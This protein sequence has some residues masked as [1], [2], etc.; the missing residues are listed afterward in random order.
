MDNNSLVKMGRII[1]LSD[2]M[3]EVIVNEG[4]VIDMDMVKE[5]H[6]WIQDNLSDPCTLLVNKIYPYTYTFE[7]QKEIASL[8]KIKAMAVVVYNRISEVTTRD[9]VS[10]PREREWYIQIFNSRDE[11]LLWL[12][13]LS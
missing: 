3:A 9:L 8:E 10:F 2:D 4:V 5:Y 12:E 13:S 11:A 1:K 7:A 6:K